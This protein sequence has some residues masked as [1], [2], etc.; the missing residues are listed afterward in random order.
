M[1]IT[2]KTLKNAGKK[3]FTKLDADEIVKEGIS[4]RLMPYRF[5]AGVGAAIT[6]VSAATSIG[7]EVKNAYMSTGHGYTQ[8]A[9]NLDR[10]I[11]IDGTGFA[12]KVNEVSGGDRAITK[13]IV[14]STF[15]NPNQKFAYNNL[16]FALHN[17]REG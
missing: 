5:T 11:S 7:G 1:A 9:E 6:G 16:V 15:D 2:M 17:R 13:E 4:G 14:K 10:L 8:M 12:N 3:V